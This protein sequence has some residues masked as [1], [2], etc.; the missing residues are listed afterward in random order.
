M[1]NLQNK[2]NNSNCLCYFEH[3]LL[4]LADIENWKREKTRFTTENSKMVSVMKYKWKMSL[5]T[6]AIGHQYEIKTVSK[7]E[8]TGMGLE[9][10]N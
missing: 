3:A 8:V 5:I 7:F 6:I 2:F 9:P 10:T 4:T 1:S